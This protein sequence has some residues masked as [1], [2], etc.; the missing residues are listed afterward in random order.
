MAMKLK[1]IIFTYLI[2]FIGFQFCFSQEKSKPLL[3][4]S[5]VPSNCEFTE[6]ATLHLIDELEKNPTSIGYIIISQKRLKSRE[7]NLW[8]F[9]HQDIISI[10]IKEKNFN[11]NRLQIIRAESKEYKIDFYIASDVSNK[12]D[13]TE[14]KWDLNIPSKTI[15]FHDGSGGGSGDGLCK[16]TLFQLNAFSEILTANPTARGHFVIYA[17]SI[18]NFPKEKERLTNEITKVGIPLN[19]FK[20]FFR[21]DNST[22]DPHSKLWLVPYNKK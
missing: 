2:L 20:F 3:L 4:E 11:P 16:E 5:V 6:L 12:P 7:F 14:A 22:I 17:D 1:E 8:G 15:M 9:Y 13:F 18:K 21:R 19:R 10:Q